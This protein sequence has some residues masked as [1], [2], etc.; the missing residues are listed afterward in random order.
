MDG[1]ASGE[2]VAR[3]IQK[4]IHLFIMDLLGT[5]R[6]AQALFEI[7]REIGQDEAIEAE[8]ENISVAL[9]QAPE[10]EKFLANP[11][12]K[13]EQ[14][15]KLWERVYHEKNSE[16]HKVLLNFFMVLFEKNRFYL[17][18]EIASCFKKIADQ[19][20][21]QCVAEICS[22]SVLKPDVEKQIT[23]HLEKISDTKITMKS[24][25]DPLLIG[26]VSIKMRNKVLDDSIKNKIHL[27]K[28]EL[29]RFHSVKT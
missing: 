22:A 2:G 17:I 4:L 6:Y 5:E 19:A 10:I 14:K 9:K 24:V 8:L 12:L 21:G 7:V 25:V 20:Q 23:N 1:F 16:V 26:G 13:I 29:L 11:A 3:K 15:R 28:T 18:H 27:I